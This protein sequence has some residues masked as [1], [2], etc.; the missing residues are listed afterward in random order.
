MKSALVVNQNRNLSQRRRGKFIM[1]DFKSL[2]AKYGNAIA[3]QIRDEKR[4]LERSKPADCGLVYWME[5][6]DIKHEVPHESVFSASL[7]CY[8]M[9]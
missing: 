3:K 2:K 7:Y 4:E 6:P 1:M 9:L 8:D 5:N